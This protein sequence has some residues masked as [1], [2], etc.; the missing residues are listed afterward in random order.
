MEDPHAA[1]K[2]ELVEL[3]RQWTERHDELNERASELHDQLNEAGYD[4]REFYAEKMIKPKM[5]RL[6][7]DPIEQQ[8]RKTVTDLLNKLYPQESASTSGA[9]VST[10]AAGGASGYS[11]TTDAEELAEVDVLDTDAQPMEGDLAHDKLT[12]Y[13][14]KLDITETDISVSVD[15]SGAI[16]TDGFRI[17]KLLQVLLK[18]HQSHAVSVALQA[19][20]GGC[21]GTLIAHGMGLGKS[22][23]TLSILEIWMTRFKDSRAVVICPKS[24]VNQWANELTRWEQVIKIDSYAITGGDE[25]VVRTLKPWFK[26]GGVVFIGHDQFKR[27]AEMFGITKTTIVVID[28]AHLLKQKQTNLYQTIQAMDTYRRIFLTGSPLQNNLGEYYSM[29][30]LLAPGILGA[31][32]SDFSRLYARAIEQGMLKDATPSEVRECDKHIKALRWRINDIVCEQSA[33]ILKECIPPKRECCI[34]HDCDPIVSDS[35]VIKERHNV[36]AAARDC[37]VAMISCIVDSIRKNTSD[38]IVVFSTRNDLLKELH[39]HRPGHLYMGDMSID[40]R[41]KMLADFPTCNGDIMYMATKAGGVGI[42]D[43]CGCRDV[44]GACL[45]WHII[46]C[47]SRRSASTRRHHRH[48]RIALQARKGHAW[49]ST[50]ATY[51]A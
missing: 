1:T 51:G 44:G 31:T 17:P 49:A 10:F 16:W 9:A 3:S 11:G 19:M 22:F 23:T 37:K 47:H 32:E 29:I 15:D 12:V 42:L 45:H 5:R 7:K 46:T 20:L 27:S 30:E 14:G 40:R 13:S 25:T 36:Q 8:M 39:K 21:Y 6:E 26:H 24:M 4:L 34:L 50:G 28:E 33:I 18:D 2:A 35:S 43:T 41:D 48:R 38:N